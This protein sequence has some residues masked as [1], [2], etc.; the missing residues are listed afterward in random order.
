MKI[1]A[2][3]G[4]RIMLLNHVITKEQE[5]EFRLAE[6]LGG[7]SAVIR[8]H[9]EWHPDFMRNYWNREMNG[10]IDN[11]LIVADY[12]ADRPSRKDAELR[13]IGS[14]FYYSDAL[15]QYLEAAKKED[16]DAQLPDLPVEEDGCVDTTKACFILQM[17]FY[18]R[19]GDIDRYK[20]SFYTRRISIN[21]SLNP[22]E[23]K[24]LLC[25]GSAAAA[26]IY[27]K[28]KVMAENSAENNPGIFTDPIIRRRWNA[29][30]LVLALDDMNIR[31]RQIVDA[32]EYSGESVELLLEHIRARDKK[33][34]EY[35][36]KKTAERYLNRETDDTLSGYA[37]NYPIAKENS[38]SFANAGKYPQTLSGWV[39]DGYSSEDLE[40]AIDRIPGSIFD[41]RAKKLA[42]AEVLPERP[43]YASMDIMS[44]VDEE[45]GKKIIEAHGF[46]KY[47]ERKIQSTFEDEKTCSLYYNRNNG[48][49]VE[50]CGATK[51]DISYSGATL[52]I[53]RDYD[54]WHH[55]KRSSS[56][57]DKE[58][59]LGHVEFSYNNG[60]FSEYRTYENIPVEKQ[61]GREKIGYQGIGQ[62]P[63]PRYFNDYTLA[64]VSPKDLADPD[65]YQYLKHDDIYHL[66]W[67]LDMILAAHDPE[68]R[69][70]I[71][72]DYKRLKDDPY[73]CI[74]EAHSGIGLWN[75]DMYIRAHQ[76]QFAASYLH[77]PAEEREKY[78]NA[79]VD[80]SIENDDR[81]KANAAAY[82]RNVNPADLSADIVAEIK[83]LYLN[84][85]AHP[86]DIAALKLPSLEELGYAFYESA[87]EFD[88]E[89]EE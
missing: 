38:A 8:R 66:T 17:E 45:T 63:V 58:I 29:M 75:P 50:V 81:I 7:S 16:Q 5:E 82:G 84:D 67:M 72:P 68:I 26:D 44:G 76:F 46:E 14:D 73:H 20:N 12:I 1:Y 52:K 24:S 88:M 80:L 85:P 27:D 71:C 59:G 35:I 13:M 54:H 87:N 3:D 18:R 39:I 9:P 48:D 57:F 33:M 83:D 60:L 25:E 53:W 74:M 32:Y 6:E 61:S 86:E 64:A 77:M 65:N 79:L 62:F 42:A 23:L 89:M 41:E 31:G 34:I 4:R 22:D 15:L 43:D 19:Y 56:G 30:S 40:K 36:N 21:D 37:P 28:L 2:E 47:F 11:Y 10:N 55:G 70:D 51:D 69:E 49:I 78:Y